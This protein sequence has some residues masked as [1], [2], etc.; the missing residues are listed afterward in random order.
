MR[1]W[2]LR[3]ESEPNKWWENQGTTEQMQSECTVTAKCRLN[4]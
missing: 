4:R 2:A 3:S 1:P